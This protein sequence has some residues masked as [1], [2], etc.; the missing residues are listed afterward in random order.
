MQ[1]ITYLPSK[2]L[3]HLRSHY[4]LRGN[5]HVGYRWWL[6]YDDLDIPPVLIG[7][8]DCLPKLALELLKKMRKEPQVRERRRAR[9]IPASMAFFPR[10]AWD[11]IPH[12]ENME[13]LRQYPRWC[14]S[15]SVNKS[16]LVVL[17][18][19][20]EDYPMEIWESI[21]TS[22]PRRQPR[23]GHRR[24]LPDANDLDAMYQL[25]WKREES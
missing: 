8:E 13:W 9:Y 15:Y 3:Q 18:C 6:V 23:V 12:A 16:Y 1:E 11:G 7:K 24:K 22:S 17:L 21:K 19:G 25:V 5:A 14:S 2:R 4:Q 20:H 10:Q